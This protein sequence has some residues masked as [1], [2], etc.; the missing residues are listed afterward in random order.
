MVAGPE[1]KPT[2]ESTAMNEITAGRN[3]IRFKSQGHLLAGHLHCPDG[4]DPSAQYPT[5]V[6]SPPFNQVKE[7]TG[8]IYGRQQPTSPR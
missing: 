4:F 5:V 2:E 6:F 7:Q 8:A 1:S 3:D